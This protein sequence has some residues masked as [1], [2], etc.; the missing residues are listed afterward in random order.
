[1]KILTKLGIRVY[2]HSENF[3]KETENIRK[4]QTEGTRLKDTISKL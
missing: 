2:A 3:D 4:H 1:M